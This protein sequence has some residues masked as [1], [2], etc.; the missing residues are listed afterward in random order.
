[1]VRKLFANM[2]VSVDVKSVSVTMIRP[3]IS[4]N[5]LYFETLFA[6]AEL[7]S[8]AYRLFEKEKVRKKYI[9]VNNNKFSFLFKSKEDPTPLNS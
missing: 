3:Q 6:Y 8:V 9:N 4:R 7:P 1:M 2:V 5:F